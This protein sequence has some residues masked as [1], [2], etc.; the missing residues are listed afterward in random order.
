MNFLNKEYT[1]T[2]ASVIGFLAL[3]GCVANLILAL[4]PFSCEMCIGLAFAYL[5]SFFIC[6]KID[7]HFRKKQFSDRKQGAGL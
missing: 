2:N 6:A 7:D 4:Y 3:G 1:G 5:L